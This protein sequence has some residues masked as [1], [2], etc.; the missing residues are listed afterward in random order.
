MNKKIKIILIGVLI[1][2]LLYLWP[3]S[4][5]GDA[6]VMIVYGPS[7]LPTIIPGSLIIT[8]SL[9]EYQID[10]IVSFNLKEEQFERIVVHRIVKETDKGFIIQG[11]NNPKQDAGFHKDN[12]RG[13]VIFVAPYF[14]VIF[15][16]LR[17]PVV[18][19]ATTVITFLIQEGHKRRK[20]R[21]E[22]LRRIRLGLPSKSSNLVG[23]DTNKKQKKQDYSIFYTAL[24]LN[25]LTYVV[26]QISIVYDIIPLR[27]MGDVVTGFLYRMFTASFASTLS[28]ALYFAFIVGLYF[29][30]KIYDGI[31]IKKSKHSSKVRSGSTI[32]LLL[33]KDFNPVLLAAQFLW[34]MFIL[35][36]V[37]HLLS[38]SQGFIDAVVDPCDPT[39]EIC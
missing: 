18:M 24:S 21:K 5:G 36:A 15:E 10:D 39:K 34:V 29:L 31:K 3:T 11:D 7:M 26:L 35:L 4:L 25:I 12:I 1:P 14:G 32:E 9:T 28:F 22:K 30:I 6:E 37:F 27:D 2:I 38:L 13:K 17:N 8:K 23:T 20:K 33:G 19:I 16:L